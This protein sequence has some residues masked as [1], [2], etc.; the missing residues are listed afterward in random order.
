MIP[1]KILVVDDESVICSGCQMILEEKGHHVETRM[2]CLE[3]LAAVRANHYDLILLDMKL[4]DQDGTELLKAMR[5]NDRQHCIIVMS[6][7]R[8]G[9][10]C[11]KL[12][13]TGCRG[14]SSKTVHGR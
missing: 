12:H 11:R 4:P 8:F 7:L 9:E 10:K 13:E 3:G 2:T 6:G 5:D 14:L 1:L